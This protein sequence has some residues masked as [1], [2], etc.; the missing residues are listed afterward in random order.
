[1]QPHMWWTAVEVVKLS[2]HI[3][4]A[5]EYNIHTHYVW[6]KSWS[7]IMYWIFLF[8]CSVNICIYL[9]KDKCFLLNSFNKI[10]ALNYSELQVYQFLPQASLLT[11]SAMAKNQMLSK[12]KLQSNCYYGIVTSPTAIKYRNEN[13]N[14]YLHIHFAPGYYKQKW[15]QLTVSHP[16]R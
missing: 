3:V 9:N 13:L 5:V 7:K 2:L 1:M 16:S 11:T 15:K 12:V 6:S 10:I 8:T 14:C 4:H